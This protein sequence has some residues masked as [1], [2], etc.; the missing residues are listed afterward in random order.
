MKINL[1]SVGKW[2]KSP[3]ADLFAHYQKRLPWPL[4]L[5]ELEEKRPLSGPALMAAEAE[6]ILGAIPSTSF[7]VA[8]DPRGVVLSSED[9]ASRLQKVR[10]SHGEASFIIGGADGLSDKVRSRAQLLLSL[11]SMIWPHLLVRSLLA[12]QLYRAW[13]I[14]NNHPYHRG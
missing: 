9:F 10:E 5:R 7:V 3:E 2:K 6:L 13:S 1:I 14:L 8:L 4:L 12:E 11:G